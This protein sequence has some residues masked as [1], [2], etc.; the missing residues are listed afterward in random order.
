MCV[1]D[2][3]DF[4]SG[5]DEFGV[6]LVRFFAGQ[7]GDARADQSGHDLDEPGALAVDGFVVRGRE[8]ACFEGVSHGGEELVDLAADF[9]VLASS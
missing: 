2:L 1:C 9:V 6:G 3:D 4:E 7:R 8:A 5:F